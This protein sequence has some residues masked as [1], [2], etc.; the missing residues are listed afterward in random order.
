MTTPP[1]LLIAGHGTRDDAG[2]EAFRDFVREL[3]A[4]HPELPVAG[5][6]IELSPPPLGEAVAELVER[7][8]RRFAAVPLMLVSAGHAKGDIPAAL[9]RE[10]ERHPGTS[11]TRTGARSAR[12]RHC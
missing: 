6:F 3:G 4:R 1:A 7:G 2:A 11:R 12:T 10:Q 5:G 8:V 9:A